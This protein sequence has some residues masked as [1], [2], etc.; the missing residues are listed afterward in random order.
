M[1]RIKH[2]PRPRPA[3]MKRGGRGGDHR[4]AR[5]HGQGRRRRA[6]GGHRRAAIGMR[7]AREHAA[8]TRR[9]EPTARGDGNAG[10]T[11]RR[12][13]YMGYVWREG[14]RLRDER[15]GGGKMTR[16]SCCIL[17]E[18]ERLWVVLRLDPSLPAAQAEPD[19][20]RERA[21]CSR[22]CSEQD[23]H[24]FAECLLAHCCS[25]LGSRPAPI[26]R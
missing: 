9:H 13:T 23:E 12:H 24:P 5:A 10:M 22:G 4:A 18:Y 15:L 11:M 8:S 26:G 6:R 21:P 25:P 2:G 3:R 7:R 1:R 20:Y 16:D 14:T 17:I 19:R